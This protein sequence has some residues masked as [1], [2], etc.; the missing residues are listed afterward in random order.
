MTDTENLKE[1]LESAIGHYVTAVAEKL[2]TE[3]LPVTSVHA[4]GAYDD[5]TQ[6]D[7]DDVE[8]ESTSPL[9]FSTASSL[10]AR[11]GSFGRAH[12]AGASSYY[13]R[14]NRRCTPA[15]VGSAMVSCRLPIG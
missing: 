2:L 15:R 1:D 4:Y 11:R 6:K 7:P 5:A 10:E 8:G 3:G 13:P 9:L 12:P 14:G